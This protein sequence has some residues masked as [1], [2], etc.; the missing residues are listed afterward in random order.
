MIPAPS[1]SDLW[2]EANPR[3]RA[4]A[5]SHAF[6]G[7][8]AWRFCNGTDCPIGNY[9]YGT[10]GQTESG[11]RNANPDIAAIEDAILKG[12]VIYGPD[13]ITLIVHATKQVVGLVNGKIV[14]PG[15]PAVAP[16]AP[17]PP[18]N[19]GSGVPIQAV[20]NPDGNLTG[21]QVSQMDMIPQILTILQ[22]AVKAGKL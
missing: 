6:P 16:P 15:T 13:N 17:P 20:P 9:T 19:T 8:L 1:L 22:T 3:L 11:A 10:V 14:L 4:F 21:T 5:F 18:S 12:D 7:T 2:E